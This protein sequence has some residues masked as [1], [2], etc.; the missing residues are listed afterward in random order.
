[1]IDANVS[2]FIFKAGTFT[3]SCT[4]FK[5]FWN[6]TTA[7]GMDTFVPDGLN[8]MRTSPRPA[9]GGRLATVRVTDLPSSA[10]VNPPTVA[11]WGDTLVTLGGKK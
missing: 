9:S 6:E 4:K 7:E 2:M 3:L 5:P 11:F 8:V 10:P 1:M